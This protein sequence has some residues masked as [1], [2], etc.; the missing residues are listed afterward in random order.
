MSYVPALTTGVC[1]PSAYQALLLWNPVTWGRDWLGGEPRRQVTRST[2]G[3]LRAGSGRHMIEPRR[4]VQM[5]KQ[6]RMPED[7]TSQTTLEEPDE[8]SSA[9]LTIVTLSGRMFQERIPSALV[10]QEQAL[11]A[12][13]LQSGAVKVCMVTL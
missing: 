5:N 6:E 7:F 1:L 9:T 3:P 4:R 12:E 11:C 2:I 8:S 13:L 10:P